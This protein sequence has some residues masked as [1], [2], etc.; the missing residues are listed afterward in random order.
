MDITVAWGYGCR[1]AG[2]MAIN[3]GTMEF[4]Q[5][6][7]PK[8]SPTWI[9]RYAD[10][11]P[12]INDAADRLSSRGYDFEFQGGPIRYNPKRQSKIKKTTSLIGDNLR[13]CS[14]LLK[15]GK[16]NP[17]FETGLSKTIRNSDVLLFNGGNLIHHSPHRR[18]QPYVLAILYPLAI[19][20]RY[21]I[22]YGLLPQT[23]FNIEGPY[24]PIIISILED[25]EF[26]WTR[27]DF[28]YQYLNDRSISTPIKQGLD[29]GFLGCNRY[30]R[31]PNQKNEHIG[32]VPRFTE[33]GDTGDIDKDHRSRGED[34]LRK[35]MRNLVTRGKIV[36][37]VVQTLSERAWVDQNDEFLESNGI[38]VFESFDQ[39]EL[40]SFYAQCDL[41]VTMRLHAGIFGLTQGTP[42][43]GIYRNGWGPKMAGTWEALGIPEF[44]KSWDEISLEELH[45][46]TLSALKNRGELRKKTLQNIDGRMEHMV[47]Q[48]KSDINQITS[49]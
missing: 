49:N 33:L 17:S 21:D 47:E 19:A 38:E 8:T 40:C 36:S 12:E 20:K 15:L 2:D 23:M 11:A 3:Y 5:Q 30:S 13:Y 35:Y 44:V 1:N 32:I 39:D 29:I 37:V 9:S 18:F 48:L 16:I 43:I 4:L 46:L 27:D 34:I 7:F 26:I 31:D 10:G 41:L 14:D 6:K 45:T 25:A 28:T 42:S 24:E 22:P